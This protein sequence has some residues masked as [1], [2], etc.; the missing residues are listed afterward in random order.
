[1][2][3]SITTLL[4]VATALAVVITIASMM[5]VRT[6]RR[7]AQ[8]ENR[9][10]TVR[11]RNA[12]TPV[13]APT[14][15]PG[16]LRIV[17]FVGAGIA[18]SGLL[19]SAT[20]QE[21]QETLN[22]AGFRG[23]QGL[24]LF[25]GGKL[26]ALTTFPGLAYLAL[27]SSSLAPIWHYI[28]VGGGAVLGLLLPDIIVKRKRAQQLAALRRGMP[29]ALDLMVICSEAGLSLEPAIERVAREIAIAHPVVAEELRQTDQALKLTSDR[30]TALLDMGNRSGLVSL[31]RLAATLVQS[32]Q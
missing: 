1:M 26:L 3:P 23:G 22:S 11:N 20:L 2:T 16:A 13:A 12:E 18:R 15:P 17:A 6:S 4:E 32:M 24:S 14:G 30:R 27:L 7:Q 31:K 9:L 28:A 10:R 5:L 25:V 19:S 29:D 8:I 21:F